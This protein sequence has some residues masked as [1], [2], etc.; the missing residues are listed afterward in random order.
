MKITDARQLDWSRTRKA[1]ERIQR[2]CDDA[3]YIAPES[4]DVH[5]R[6]IQVVCEELS[7]AALHIRTPGRPDRARMFLLD[8]KLDDATVRVPETG[9]DLE[10]AR[11]VVA[12]R[13]Q[14]DPDRVRPVLDEHGNPLSREVSR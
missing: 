9:R 10:E 5:Q 7:V 8:V 13:H 4:L 11:R 2:L 3:A 1:A 14:V 12:A 6:H